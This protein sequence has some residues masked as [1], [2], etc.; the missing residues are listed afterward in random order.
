V[1]VAKLARQQAM[2][3]VLIG[4]G[5]TLLPAVFTRPWVGSWATDDRAKVLGRALGA[6][7]LALGAAG[8]LA[9][10]EERTDWAARAFAAQAYADAIDLAA[11][12]GGGRAVPLGAR[13]LGGTMAAGS[14]AVAALYA[15]Q[16]RRAGPG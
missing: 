14:A 1:D 15:R 8:L 4:A 13:L 16:L 9:L 6:R 2:N 5:L 10:R 12:L 11:I 3:R 7:D